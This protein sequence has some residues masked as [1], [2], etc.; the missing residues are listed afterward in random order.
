MTLWLEQ[1]PPLRKQK[2]FHEFFILVL[3]K[4]NLRI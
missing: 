4:D 2:I 1:N 3:L